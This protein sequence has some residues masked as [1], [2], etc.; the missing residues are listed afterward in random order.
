MQP[1]SG[2]LACCPG[3]DREFLVR[4]RGFSVT[5]SNPYAIDPATLLVL[6]R[7]LGVVRLE[8]GLGNDRGLRIHL[9]GASRLQLGDSRAERAE[10]ARFRLLQ[11]GLRNLLRR[12]PYVLQN[13]GAL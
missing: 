5:S 7:P 3:I 10:R 9:E 6:V 8:L 1:S 13:L 4:Y 12:P 2:S 11:G